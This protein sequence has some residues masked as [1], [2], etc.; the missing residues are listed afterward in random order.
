MDRL[1]ELLHAAA[2]ARTQARDDLD[3]DVPGSIAFEEI[4]GCVRHIAAE[5]LERVP[6]HM[7]PFDI[8]AF[9]APD[10]GVFIEGGFQ[11]C[12]ACCGTSR[13]SLCHVCRLWRRQHFA[14]A[15]AQNLYKR[16]IRGS[17]VRR[18]SAATDLDD[19]PVR[20]RC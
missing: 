3:V 17:L 2:R 1:A 5:S 14:G 16:A 18:D 7:Q 10:A 12:D 6:L 4:G 8:G 19:I 13:S 11:D 9:H 15:A 20:P